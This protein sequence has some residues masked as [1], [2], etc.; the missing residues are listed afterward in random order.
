MN[1]KVRQLAIFSKY[2]EAVNPHGLA[3]NLYIT[4]VNIWG[5]GSIPLL[6]VESTRHLTLLRHGFLACK[7]KKII[8]SLSKVFF[9]VCESDEKHCSRLLRTAVGTQKA[10]QSGSWYND[11]NVRGYKSNIGQPLSYIIKG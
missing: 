2:D 10:L 5:L 11:S 4:W 1:G 9:C 6:A 3:W 8:K 7:M